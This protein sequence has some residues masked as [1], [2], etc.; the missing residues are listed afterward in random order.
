MLK[1]TVL[2]TRTHLL[3]II[4]IALVAYYFFVPGASK[5][6][7]SE[8]PIPELMVDR[9]VLDLGKVVS[10]QKV[11]S[12][13]LLTNS[14]SKNIRI[15]EP[16]VSCGCSEVRIV[17]SKLQP[18]KGTELFV[19]INVGS[20]SGVFVVSILLPYQVGL[21]ETKKYIR[22]TVKFEVVSSAS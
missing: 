9:S 22:L 5:K 7:I 8:L 15:L 21:D 6:P 11:K 12:I 18:R 4:G 10:N 14:V 16:M 1:V 13:F 19:N 17:E 2:K 3:L 20:V